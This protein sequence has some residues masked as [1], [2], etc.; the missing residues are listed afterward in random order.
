MI[1]CAGTIGRVKRIERSRRVAQQ[2]GLWLVV[3][4]ICAAGCGR[5]TPSSPGQT[6]ATSE[7][8]GGGLGSLFGASTD[9]SDESATATS[10]TTLKTGDVVTNSIG[11]KL[12]VFP[13]G[14]F[15]MG[16]PE[17][18]EK[19]SG[20]ESRHTVRLSKPAF[21]GIYEVTQAEFQLVMETN[22]SGVTDSD[23]LPVQNISWEQAVAFCRKLPELPAGRVG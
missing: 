14:S 1:G 18:E 22:P 8:G 9:S 19:R 17:T 13:P 5:G 20:D 4:V 7:S 2:V 11:M 12:G 16:S 23:R 21:M 6:E 15:S 3:L 10:P